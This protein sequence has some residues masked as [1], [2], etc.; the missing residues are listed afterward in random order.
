MKNF[1][2][3]TESVK[4]RD[5]GLASYQSYLTMKEHPNHEDATNAI[6]EIYGKNA[7]KNILLDTFEYEKKQ[8]IERVKK[9]KRGRYKLDS[10]AQSF[11]LSV[12]KINEMNVHIRPT[13][14]Q[15]NLIFKD[16]VRNVFKV[17]NSKNKYPN[18]TLKDLTK[19]TYAN[20]HE[21]RDG[22][23][24]LNLVFGK[25]INNKV[26]KELTQYA[27][28]D[29]VK[30]T[31]T[32]SLAKHCDLKLENYKPVR[33][34]L[35]KRRNKVAKQH[36]IMQ[37]IKL[38]QAELQFNESLFKSIRNY[39]NNIEKE[40]LDRAEMWRNAIEKDMQD[41]EK[42]NIEKFGTD[43]AYKISDSII[44]QLKPVIEQAEKKNLP[45][46]KKIRG[47]RM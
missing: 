20:V 8:G 7:F 27:V 12:P 3:S 25:L 37:K 38:Q 42:Q 33:T 1:F 29:C 18:L 21:Q 23:D 15:W 4:G 41:F 31:F 46:P 35:P 26:V 19:V 39:I 9:G 2:V 10:F 22:N 17:I 43:K 44:E 6:Y 47:P 30:R 13:K 45:I 11:V 5:G 28:L 16:V 32:A 34:N 36:S 24:H 14:E 40:K